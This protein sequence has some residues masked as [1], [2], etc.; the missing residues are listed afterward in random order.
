MSEPNPNPLFIDEYLIF[1][2]K[3]STWRILIRIAT[4][5]YFCF[6]TLMLL[7][8]DPWTLL[9]WA[10]TTR[11]EI[12]AFSYVHVAIFIL[13]AFCICFCDKRNH[14]YI[15]LILL[16]LYGPVT[17]VLQT[18][19]GRSFSC[20][21]IFQDTLGICLGFVLGYQTRKYIKKDIL[22]KNA[23]QVDSNNKE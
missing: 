11:L 13:L 3:I 9:G 19:T 18:Y 10:P 20:L 17:E 7:H 4:I 14:N 21:D 23:V 6:M 5:I 22:R 2:I 8:P 16:F 12:K 15:W 1:N